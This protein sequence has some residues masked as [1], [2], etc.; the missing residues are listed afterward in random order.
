MLHT[1]YYIP[2]TIY[3]ILYAICYMLYPLYYILYTIYYI[4]YTIYYTL[5]TV[6]YLPYYTSYILYTI[7]SLLSCYTIHTTP[8]L[9]ILQISPNIIEQLSLHV[10]HS[11]VFATEAAHHAFAVLSENPQAEISSK[12]TAVF[13]SKRP[14][15]LQASLLYTVYFNE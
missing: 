10:P 13:R 6:Y 8:T 12:N 15:L 5:Y 3:Y 9:S 4:L 14:A 1:I 11:F 7:Y 2:H